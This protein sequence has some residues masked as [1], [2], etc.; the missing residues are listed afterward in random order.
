VVPFRGRLGSSTLPAGQYS[1][2]VSAVPI[3]MTATHV[4]I[5][6]T[7]KFTIVG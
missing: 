5:G 1:V 4:A 2:T 7:L 6:G 3:G